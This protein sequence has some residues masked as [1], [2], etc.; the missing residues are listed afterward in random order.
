MTRMHNLRDHE[1]AAIRDEPSV[2]AARTALCEDSQSYWG[3]LHPVRKIR[4]IRR[5]LNAR[6]DAEERAGLL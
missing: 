1:P 6:L 2:V 4:L 5:Y 3:W